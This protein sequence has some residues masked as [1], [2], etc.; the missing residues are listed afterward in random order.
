MD[1]TR[2]LLF[3]FV[4]QVE[5]W[6]DGND[7]EDKNNNNNMDQ[8]MEPYEIE[9]ISTILAVTCMF[10]APLYIL[11]AVLLFFFYGDAVL[12]ESVES[13][14]DFYALEASEAPST[15]AA[16]AAFAATTPSTSNKPSDFGVPLDA[17]T[18]RISSSS[19]P[20]PPILNHLV[21]NRIG[22]DPRNG[23]FF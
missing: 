13:S 7:R 14:A 22:S 1:L 3:I 2:L 19:Q 4:V 23:P 16:A 12:M 11:F 6:S 17:T 21:V 18:A 9:R 15:A 5:D 20:A 10:L 8:R